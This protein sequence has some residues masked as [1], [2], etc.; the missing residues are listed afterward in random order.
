MLVRKWPT[1]AESY[2]GQCCPRMMKP[3]VKTLIYDNCV[4]LEI[5]PWVTEK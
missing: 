1:L 3:V 5:Y 4:K 2:V